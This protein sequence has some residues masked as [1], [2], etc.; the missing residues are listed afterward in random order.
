MVST[1]FLVFSCRDDGLIDEGKAIRGW[2]GIE[3]T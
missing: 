1:V 2:S 3:M